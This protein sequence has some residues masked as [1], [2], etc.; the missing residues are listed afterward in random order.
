MPE[1]LG[2]GGGLGDS[3]TFGTEVLT[4]LFGVCNVRYAKL[5]RVRNFDVPNV[6]SVV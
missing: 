1:G 5:F 2:G 4:C 6:L 3:L